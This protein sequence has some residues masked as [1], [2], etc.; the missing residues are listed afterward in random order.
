[1]DIIFLK[2]NC[3][4]EKS[5]LLSIY[6]V[7]RSR[8][9]ISKTLDKAAVIEKGLQLFGCSVSPFLK[10]GQTWA[11]LKSLGN[12]PSFKNAFM[13]KQRGSAITLM[14]SFRAHAGTLDG[15]KCLFMFFHKVL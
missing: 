7:V 8:M 15:N 11:C 12:S 10:I 6:L 9:T 13:R 5:L 1:M 2:R 4:G 3:T 14:E